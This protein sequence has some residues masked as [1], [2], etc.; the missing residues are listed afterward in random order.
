MG[1]LLV[2]DDEQRIRQAIRAMLKPL[3]H[4]IIEAENGA[5]GPALLAQNEVDLV[6]T[7][8]IMPGTEGIETV[9]AIRRLRPQMKIVALSGTG[10]SWLYLEAAEKLGADAVL[11]KPF[12]PAEPR[13]VVRRVLS[14][15]QMQ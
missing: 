5:L 4:S 15:N 11:N 7:D 8:M 2:I 6:L 1:C 14:E 3:R 13:E 10:A 12:R 9:Q